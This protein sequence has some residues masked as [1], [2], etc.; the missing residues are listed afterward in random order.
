MKRLLG[1]LVNAV[2][3]PLHIRLVRIDPWEAKVAAR[4]A[5]GSGPERPWDREFARW[6]VEAEALGT[7]PNDLGDAAWHDDPLHEALEKY[8]L[9]HV[10]RDS[11]VLE[12]GP[13]TGRVTRHVIHRCRKMVL[14]DYSRLVCA[15]LRKYLDGKGAFEV[16]R[17]A[18][19][20]LEMIATDS[21]DVILANG[22]FEHVDLDDMYRFFEEFHRVLKA[23]GVV[24][25]NF[26]N[27]MS[28]EGVEWF[29]KSRGPAGA[30]CIFRFHHPDVV[31]RLADLAG[32]RVLGIATGSTRFAYVEMQK[33][34]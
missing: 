19:P 15:W 17:I 1:R 34:G 28:P 32:F 3:Q 6:L 13:G 23:G 11:T 2:L 12:L 16:H 5:A 9:P 26:D 25:F 7:D 18:G 21:I 29:R 27:I 31:H 22:V 14:V 30:R 4:V 8:Y 24:A 10:T 33:A 20:S